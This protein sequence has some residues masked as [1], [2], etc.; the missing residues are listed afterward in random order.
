[1]STIV[2][3]AFREPYLTHNDNQVAVLT[4][5]YQLRVFRD[6][7]PY[8]EGIVKENIVSRFQQSLYGFKP[9]AIELARQS[10][11]DK[12]IWFDPSLYPLS[13]ID[14]LFDELDKTDMLV[15]MGDHPIN[16]M[17]ND[18][19]IKWFGLNRSDLTDVKHIGGTF[20]GFNFNNPKTAEVFELWKKAEEEGIFGTQDEF[21]AGHWA[22]ESCMTL[23][24]FKCGV[25]QKNSKTLKYRNQKD[26]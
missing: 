4:G 9:H 2:T 23:A 7:L 1:M 5:N 6:V 12:V 8:K 20:Y 17:T 11:A 26:S 3:V 22:D 19:A 21:M 25:E 24:M 14:D 10:G 13:S 18:K 15:K 16:E